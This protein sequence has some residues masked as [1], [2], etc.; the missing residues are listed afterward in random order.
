MMRAASRSKRQPNGQFPLTAPGARQQQIG[1][2]RASNQ[3]NQSYGACKNQDRRT[4]LAGEMLLQRCGGD[5][6]IVPKPA[7]AKFL[8]I[9]RANRERQAIH[10]RRGFEWRYVRLAPG[11]DGD[12][13]N[14][15]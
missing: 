5:H 3:Q 15:A 10:L 4:H 7:F 12:N 6:Q 14:G 11:H 9:E 13:E 8:G 1:D 2:V